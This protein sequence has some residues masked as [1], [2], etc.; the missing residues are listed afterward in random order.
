MK[1][2]K[3]KKKKKRK[4]KGDTFLKCKKKWCH[5]CHMVCTTF[6]KL[7]MIKLENV[8][9]FKPYAA[10]WMEVSKLRQTPDKKFVGHVEIYSSE[11]RVVQFHIEC[12]MH[13]GWWAI[14][15]FQWNPPK[16][17]GI[18]TKHLSLW[19]FVTDNQLWRSVYDGM[20]MEDDH[21]T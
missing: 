3:L 2:E 16:I 9:M 5:E 18:S 4:N 17:G 13:V 1:G 8:R 10:H 11:Q 19:Y 15:I 6:T 7:N 14:A 20:L 12:E 21:T